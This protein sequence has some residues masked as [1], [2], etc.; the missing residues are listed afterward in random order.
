MTPYR[1]N[2]NGSYLSLL[3]SLF[4]D[5]EVIIKYIYLFYFIIHY[6]YLL[7]NKFLFSA[8]CWLIYNLLNTKHFTQ[9]LTRLLSSVNVYLFVI[10][11]LNNGHFF[12]FKLF[13]VLIGQGKI[14]F[15]FLS[16]LSKREQYRSLP[17]IQQTTFVH[18]HYFSFMNSL[19][20]NFN[21]I[22][23]D[24]LLPKCI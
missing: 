15:K 2:A 17:K 11:P 12:L 18:S 10:P 14:T 6:A 23:Q 5:L 21:K 8:W 19:D 7:D 3:S 24:F 22:R 16:Y 4:G 1:V 13:F 9:T 20:R